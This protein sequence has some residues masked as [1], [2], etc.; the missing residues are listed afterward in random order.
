MRAEHHQKR[1]R[2]EDAEFLEISIQSMKSTK[3][4]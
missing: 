4:V 1:G 3:V 2:H